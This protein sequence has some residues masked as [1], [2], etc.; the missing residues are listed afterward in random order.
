MD[1]PISLS[2][3]S[4]DLANEPAFQLGSALVDPQAHEC[5]IGDA[6]THLQ[7]QTAKVLVALHDKSGHVVTRDELIDRCWNGRIVGDDVINRCISLLRPLA[8]KSG[9]F[10]IE[11]I[12]RSG[13][14]LVEIDAGPTGSAGTVP[15][16]TAAIIIVLALAAGTATFFA[17]RPSTN[18]ERPL[19]VD[20]L[21]FTAQQGSGAGRLASDVQDSVVRMLTQSG[22]S[23]RSGGA[24]GQSRDG[25]DMVVSGVVSTSAQ[26]DS[27]SIRIED[28]HRNAVVLSRRIDADA[29]HAAD[30]P[31]RVG[32]NI[33]AVLSWTG[34]LIL[35]DGQHPSDPAFIAEMLTGPTNLQFDA[36]NEYEFDSRNAPNAPGSPVAQLA[37]AMDTGFMVTSLP[38]EQRASA[39]A[40]GLSAAQRARALAPSFGDVYIPWCLLHS[41]VRM[42]ECENQLRAGL[43]ADA[44]APFV[45]SFLTDLMNEVGRIQEA[46]VLSRASLAEDR[47]VPAKL[48]KAIGLSEAVGDSA[49][50]DILFKEADRLWPH[51]P[52]IFWYRAQGILQRGD[53][54]A[55]EKFE[56]EVGPDHLPG[57]YTSVVPVERALKQHS[58]PQLAKACPKDAGNM[59][60]TECMIAFTRIGD[61]N[62]AFAFADL[63]YPS[64]W[65]KTP[66]EEERIWLDHP[67]DTTKAYLSIQVMAPM[68]RD[69]RFLTLAQRTGLLA[70]WRSGR[71]PDFCMR[72]HEAVCTRIAAL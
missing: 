65:A 11:T 60:A 64:L 47:Y 36:L 32:A 3:R 61:L 58:Q 48:A 7:P 30:L 8:A 69:P 40:N 49:D 6:S 43:A 59:R 10:R 62:D 55:L 12:P 72:D 70:Y 50:A 51:F 44:D 1:R 29:A 46:E 31:D 56:H 37:Y 16:R 17:L 5:V 71:L 41:P 54:E 66:A 42:R 38:A 25:A 67:V 68:R 24:N 2:L 20:V 35:M 63:L 4:V 13:Y 34:P 52:G 28:V 22:L 27:A 21:P 23:V 45:A 19:V 9:G 57:R 15:W 18:I 14:R 26:G 33:S 39:L 53:F